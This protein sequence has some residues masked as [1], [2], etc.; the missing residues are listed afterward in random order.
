MGINIKAK[1]F[2]L[3]G[4]VLFIGCGQVKTQSS[5]EVKMLKDFYTSYITECSQYPAAT[6]IEAANAIKQKYCTIRFLKNMEKQD[7]DYDPF[8]NAQDCDREWIKS[9]SISKDTETEN[10]YNISYKDISNDDQITVKLIVV[11]EADG[12]KIDEILE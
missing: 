8:L 1:T 12:F 6:A 11:K 2:F 4:I 9:L 3:F 7:L 5:D 10:M